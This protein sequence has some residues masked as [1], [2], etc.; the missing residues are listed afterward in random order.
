MFTFGLLGRL[1]TWLGRSTVE[2][3]PPSPI[4]FLGDKHV[5]RDGN[6]Y[7]DAMATLLPRGIAWPRDD[8]SELM[9]TVSG[10]AQIFG[11]VDERQSDLLEIETDP[12]QTIEMLPDWERN[13]GLPEECIAEP[14]TIGDRQKVLVGKMTLLGGQSRA[15]Y[16]AVAAD[17][18][19]EIHIEEYAPFMC[20]I[21]RC[22]DTS[23]ENVDAGG[24]GGQRFKLDTVNILTGGVLTNIHG[25]SVAQTDM[26]FTMTEHTGAGPHSFDIAVAA[27]QRSWQYYLTFR[28]HATVSP[29]ARG[30]RCGVRNTD[31][32]SGW[33]FEFDDPT[34]P[35]KFSTGFIQ[36]NTD[37]NIIGTTVVPLD[38]P[39]WWQI[40]V[41]FTSNELTT[42]TTNFELLDGTD[43]Y[44]ANG[45]NYT[46]DGASGASITEV[47]L[48]R[49]LQS[50]GYWRW[51]I[52]PPEM[53][54]YWTVFVGAVR[55][56]WFRAAK[57][58]LGVDPHLRISIAT[59]L[60][61]LLGRWKPAHTEIIFDYSGLQA[62]TSSMQGTP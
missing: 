50:G 12:R 37:F 28:W 48:V 18:G 21:S 5:R 30:L 44:L 38:D 16:I 53:R 20:G 39:D 11:F 10:L 46:G 57:G 26:D 61:C 6:D 24:Y 51:Y 40:S 43:S 58:E 22:G 60:E 13:W 45:A 54:F 49:L 42:F 4:I 29:N 35:A 32:T 36:D 8:D 15:F 17:L 1:A 27:G 52:G 41:S 19:H 59:D 2:V 56:I 34:N 9:K 14:Q 62:I 31:G 55:L 23:V 47:Q 3:G 7:A 25:A 33:Y